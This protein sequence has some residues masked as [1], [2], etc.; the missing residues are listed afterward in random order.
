MGIVLKLRS[1]VLKLRSPAVPVVSIDSG[2]H[3]ERFLAARDELVREH[4]HLVPPIAGR[5]RSSL[6]P[7]FDVEDL[8]AAGNLALLHCATRYRPL[9]HGGVPFS[10]FA[11]PRIRGAMFD[12]IRRHQWEENTRPLRG[13][14][15]GERLPPLDTS[16]EIDTAIDQRR[17]SARLAKEI[18]RLPARQRDVI[19]AYYAESLPPLRDPT[20]NRFID[21]NRGLSATVGAALG[22]PEWRVDREH[23]DAIAELR[24]RLRAA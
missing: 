15:L 22:L 18:M 7:S 2:G 5:I 1:P 4:L 16:I 20:T 23:A 12:S 19:A 10:A 8:I 9:E 13:V 6:P 24:R 3:R 14:S 21:K 11:R 17:L